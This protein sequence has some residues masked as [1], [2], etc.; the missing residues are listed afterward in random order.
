MSV[1]DRPRRSVSDIQE[2]RAERFEVEIFVSTSL[3]LEGRDLIGVI[4]VAPQEDH[5]NTSKR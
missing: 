4:G 2:V 5:R 3:H 1:R